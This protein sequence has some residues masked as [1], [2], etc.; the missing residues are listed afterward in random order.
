[1][2]AHVADEWHGLFATRCGAK[3]GRVVEGLEREGHKHLT[4]PLTDEVVAD[5]RAG[6]RV[7]ITGEL[8][9][10]RDAAHERLVKLI[11]A[12]EPLPFDPKGQ[13][14]YYVGPTPPRPGAIIGSAGP[15]TALRMDAYAPALMAAGI[16]G[17]IGKGN[18][19]PEVRAALQKYHSVYF[20]A[21]GGAGA[22]L[23]KRITSVEIVC[24]EELGTEAIR[25]L[26]VVDFPAVVVNDIYG[27]D[28]YE[29]ARAQ[30]AQT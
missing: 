30:Y 13:I 14:I 19:G 2:K 26:G 16:K 24:Y 17:M 7:L 4:T 11:E 15:T 5:L 18:R 27:A 23:A 12:G 1:M 6:D 10:A 3:G 9:T 29:Q 8:L 28:L 21:V 20:A 22:L 25:R